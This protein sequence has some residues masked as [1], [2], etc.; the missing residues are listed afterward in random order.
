MNNES[1]ANKNPIYIYEI[2]EKN[3][4]IIHMLSK[5]QINFG[6]II[7]MKYTNKF[8]LLLKV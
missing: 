5:K 6:I 1:L 8:K 2:S 3:S 4:Y 7:V